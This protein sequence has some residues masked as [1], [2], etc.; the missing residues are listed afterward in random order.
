MTDKFGLI[1]R[2]FYREVE[3]PTEDVT[4][5]SPDVN[6]KAHTSESVS[7]NVNV[8][9]SPSCCGTQWMF[10]MTVKIPSFYVVME[11]SRNL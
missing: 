9:L 2:P 3:L 10:Y 6:A 5:G 4:G 11:D 7:K 8:N 1:Q